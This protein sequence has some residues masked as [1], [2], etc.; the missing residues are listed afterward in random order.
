MTA[1]VKQI[2]RREFSYLVKIIDHTV[3]DF[4]TATDEKRETELR[5]TAIVYADEYNKIHSSEKID[6]KLFADEIVVQ[7]RE[8]CKDSK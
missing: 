2:A 5:N 6:P 8:K 4:A 7:Y 3:L 1:D